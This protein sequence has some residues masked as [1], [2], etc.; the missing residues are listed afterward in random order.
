MTVVVLPVLLLLLLGTIDLGMLAYYRAQVR[1]VATSA[2]LSAVGNQRH[3]RIPV[4]THWVVIFVP[5]PVDGWILN[6]LWLPDV[7]L[8]FAGLRGETAAVA[9][10]TGSD[11]TLESLVVPRYIPSPIK[12]VQITARVERP[13]LLRR[14]IAPGPIEHT[15][16]AIAWMRPDYWRHGWWSDK[17]LKSVFHQGN[18]PQHY[19]RLT[20]CGLTSPAT[21][22]E[23]MAEAH[24]AAT[25]ETTALGSLAAQYQD[26]LRESDTHWNG[27][28]E[29]SGRGPESPGEV[30]EC[31]EIGAVNCRAAPQTV[32]CDHSDDSFTVEP[33]EWVPGQSYPTV[34]EMKAARCP[35]PPPPPDESA[36]DGESG[37]GTPP[38]EQAS[39]PAPTT[40][41]VD[42]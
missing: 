1:S 6:T 5:I 39:E 30:A 15:A 36:G 28:T 20:K 14:F 38:P 10:M 35:P 24:L 12:W 25:G 21:L 31:Q 37:D 32:H 34:A 13:G 40:G 17:T 9:E 22:I 4:P 19:Y 3:V 2:A 29:Y 26:M 11:I 7:D 27:E 41:E 23:V 33:Q 42:P 8:P 16:C 18:E